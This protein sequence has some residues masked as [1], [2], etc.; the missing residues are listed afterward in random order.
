MK[1]MLK[2]VAVYDIVIAVI[3]ILVSALINPLFSPIL[4]L[5]IATAVFS[6]YVNA[7]TA[8]LVLIQKA[9]NKT[10]MLLS[11][12]FRVI[13]ICTVGIILYRINKYYLF[14][15]IVGYSTHFIAIIIYGLLMK[16]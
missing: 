15:Y 14:A 10:L 11:S 2:A 13:L 8:D 7:I 6:Y 1:R 9:G 3:M 12:S 5:G 4:L 16:K